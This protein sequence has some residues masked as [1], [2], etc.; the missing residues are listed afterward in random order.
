VNVE[1]MFNLS[2]RRQLIHLQVAFLQI[3][4]KEISSCSIDEALKVI[5]EFCLKIDKFFFSGETCACVRFSRAI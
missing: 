3:V 1:K 5:F 4:I 2:R